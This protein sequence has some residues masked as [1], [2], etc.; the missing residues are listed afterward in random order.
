MTTLDKSTLLEPSDLFASTH[1]IT[2]RSFVEALLDI[3]RELLPKDMLR[4]ELVEWVLQHDRQGRRA[5]F[6]LTSISSAQPRS[7]ASRML[8]DAVKTALDHQ[9]PFCATSLNYI[10]DQRRIAQRV[11]DQLSKALLPHNV[12]ASAQA[13]QTSL[14]QLVNPESLYGPAAHLLAHATVESIEQALANIL[15]ERNEFFSQQLARALRWWDL[16]QAEVGPLRDSILLLQRAQ[17]I[18]AGFDPGINWRD[19]DLESAWNQIWRPSTMRAELLREG[20]GVA[21]E[22]EVA[23]TFDIVMVQKAIRRV[24]HRASILPQREILDTIGLSRRVAL[25]LGCDTHESRLRVDA[26]IEVMREAL[27]AGETVRLPRLGTLTVEDVANAA[28][29]APSAVPSAPRRRIRFNQSRTLF[30]ASSIPSADSSTHGY[31]EA[32]GVPFDQHYLVT[33]SHLIGRAEELDWLLNRLRAPLV[34]GDDLCITGIIGMGGIGKSALVGAA[35]EHLRMEHRLQDG[36][37]VIVCQGMT[38]ARDIL[39]RVLAKFDPWRRLPKTTDFSGLMTTAKRILAGKDA[40]IVLDDVEL[41]LDLNQIVIPLRA[42]GM[43]TVLISRYNLPEDLVHKRDQYHLGRL[44]LSEAE[45]LFAQEMGRASLGDFEPSERVAAERMIIALGRHTL[46]VQLAGAYAANA[47][48]SLQ[49]LY[50]A[51]SEPLSSATVIDNE[52]IPSGLALI[53][54]RSIEDLPT[55]VRRFFVALGAFATVE[56]GR[57]AAIYVG[58]KLGLS[59]I[60]A[61]IDL[62]AQRNLIY[63][64]A[65]RNMPPSSD[66][67][68][69]RLHP[70]MYTRARSEFYTWSED[71]QVA[72]NTAIAEYFVA[73]VA[74]VEERALSSD[75]VNIAGT[76][77]WARDYGRNDVT[78]ALCSGM[79][80]FWYNRWYTQ[81][82]LRYLPDG[83]AAGEHI[84]RTIGHNADR[85]TSAYLALTYAQVLRRLGH[86]DEAEQSLRR[87]LDIRSELGDRWGEAAVLSQLGVVLRIRGRMDEAEHCLMRSLHIRRDEQDTQGEGFDLSQLG[88]IAQ[89]RGR[90]SEADQLYQRSLILAKKSGDIRTQ[91]DVLAFLGQLARVRGQLALAESY[92]RDSLGIMVIVQDPRGRCVALHELGQIARIRG[93]L[94]EAEAYFTQCLQI[95]RDVQDRRGEGKALGYLGRISKM[96][97]Q[98]EMAENYFTQSLAMAR[99]VQDR[100]GEG[101]VLSQFGQI[102]LLREDL[103]H[104]KEFFTASLSIRR[105]VQDRKSEG[106]D[107][108]YLARIALLQNN[109][110]GA[111]SLLMQNLEIARETEDRH[112]ESVVLALL[113]RIAERRGELEQ[114]EMRLRA[115]LS[116]AKEGENK[117][118]EAETMLALGIFTAEHLGEREE[119]QELIRQ[120]AESFSAMGLP[121]ATQAW[122]EAER[123]SVP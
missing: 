121:Q 24:A 82:I 20:V 15:R 38:D 88:R 29:R 100:R 56:F 4:H 42:S 51:L 75:K 118:A 49:D 33:P 123:L 103:P 107:L 113:A 7:R 65:L 81:E 117:P 99:D 104:A 23:P 12:A 67:H 116:L 32:H 120:A 11:L 39:G 85:I 83:M 80:A 110:P 61:N 109:L 108:G 94:D 31:K 55:D 122:E 102:A 45:T 8:A 71:E 89:A 60:E 10:S 5:G 98:L 95:N 18:L 105:E 93:R 43:R 14:Q 63:K 41:G 50:A 78:L 22:L 87:N 112:G 72:V 92:F 1:V 53:L 28:P 69:L 47:R 36:A 37:V 111:E 115:S 46:A 59:S 74:R 26:L 84:A 21:Q 119:G 91:G 114:A 54:T 9:I 96:R 86:L 97:G 58:R 35:L 17:R 30:L 52:D 16:W 62:L 48:S 79:R 57:Q 6:Y 27:E 25:S 3:E 70:L 19:E 101:I 90:M 40:L 73:Y 77:D 66:R 44:S 13:T 34:S 106:A 64:S 68:R 76:I 2:D